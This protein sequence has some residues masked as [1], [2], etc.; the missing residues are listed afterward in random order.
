MSCLD[1]LRYFFRLCQFIGILPFRMDDDKITGRFKKF[2]YSWKYPISWWH[3][4]TS[5]ASIISAVL[6][7]EE[8]FK[9]SD[10]EDLPLIVKITIKTIIT[11]YVVLILLSRYILLFKFHTLC[12]AIQ[13][14]Q[15]IETY[16]TVDHPKN[17]NNIQLRTILGLIFVYSPVRKWLLLQYNTE[18]DYFIKMFKCFV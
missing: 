2:S 15:R 14:M 13:F 10:I 17:R 8:T 4:T 1:K 6:I 9:N 18:P 7:L 11:L 3:I 12:K 5:V 16:I